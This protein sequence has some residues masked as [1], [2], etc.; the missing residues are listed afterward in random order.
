LVAASAAIF[1]A[2]A[3]GDIMASEAAALGSVVSTV[4]KAMETRDLADRIAALEAQAAK[5]N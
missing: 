2:V 1:A 3:T 4:G 5:G